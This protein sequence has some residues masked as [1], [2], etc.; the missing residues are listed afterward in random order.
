M[1]TIRIGVGVGGAAVG[2]GCGVWVGGSVGV[3]VGAT[4][5]GVKVGI[6]VASGVVASGV[7]WA[8]GAGGSTIG[9]SVA[10][11]TYPINRRTRAPPPKTAMR[12]Q[13]RV[14]GLSFRMLI[15]TFSSAAPDHWY[16]SNGAIKSLTP[17]TGC[18]ILQVD[19]LRVALVPLLTDFY[20]ACLFDVL[21][22]LPV[23]AD[24]HSLLYYRR[25]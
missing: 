18:W 17:Q 16:E 4:G 3:E 15:L 12:A 1:T 23:H 7:G 21:L 22:R 2:V 9:K 24:I 11:I 19:E 14:D 13:R 20:L 8:I 5:E 10:P 25:P 6:S